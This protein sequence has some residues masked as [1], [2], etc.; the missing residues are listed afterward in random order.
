MR[1]NILFLNQGAIC[2]ICL[3][4]CNGLS[5]LNGLFSSWGEWGLLQLVGGPL[6]AAASLLAGLSLW[7]PGF[8]SCGTQALGHR[9]NICGTRA[10]LS[11]GMWDLLE[12]GIEPVS[13][14]LAGRLFTMEPQGKPT[15]CIFNVH[16]SL[17]TWLSW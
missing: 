13:L 10:Q 9:L 12:S 5:L 11:C 6:T 4:D 16:L 14:V 8:G 17:P 2:I 1:F 7:C 15:I 3:F